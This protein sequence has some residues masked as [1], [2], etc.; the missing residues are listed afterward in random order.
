MGSL[1]LSSTP[2]CILHATCSVYRETLN[3]SPPA[4]G[5]TTCSPPIPALRKLCSWVTGFWRTSVNKHFKN[6]NVS[7]SCSQSG[8]KSRLQNPPLPNWLLSVVVVKSL[9]GT[10]AAVKKKNPVRA[11]EGLSQKKK[12]KGKKSQADKVEMMRWG[13]VTT[14]WAESPKSVFVLGNVKLSSLRHVRGRIPLPLSL[15]TWHALSELIASL[16]GREWDG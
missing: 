12:E 4:C 14:C 16:Q 2:S 11:G 6:T 15:Q 13:L 1:A 7:T 3:I 10:T 8:W 9:C 5:S